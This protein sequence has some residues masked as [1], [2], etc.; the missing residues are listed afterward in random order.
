MPTLRKPLHLL[1]GLALTGAFLFTPSSVIAQG[2]APGDLA[3]LQGEVTVGLDFYTDYLFRGYKIND[4]PVFQPSFGLSAG[5]STLGTFSASV[6]GNMDLGDEGSDNEGEFT[7]VDYTF[8]YSRSFD[9]LGIEVG[10][11]NYQFPNTDLETTSEV[12]L[13]LSYETEVG[14][15]PGFTVYYDF[16]EAEGF[17]FNAS[18]DYS[19]EIAENLTFDLGLSAGYMDSD[20]GDFYYSGAGSGF[21]DVNLSIGGTYTINDFT[22]VSAA[23]LGTTIP[24]SDMRDAVKDPDNIYAMVGLSF[25]LGGI[26]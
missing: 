2:D 19:V 22:S 3:D 15:T 23:V 24:D 6:W 9:A 21:S 11:I 18:L 5:N 7:E 13:G 20:Q 17:Y 14:I 16:D 25:T 12:Y 10:V 1:A 8:A 4:K 26:E